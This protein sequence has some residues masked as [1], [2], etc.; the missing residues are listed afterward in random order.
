MDKDSLA[1]TKWNCIYH[2]VFIPKYRR[3]VMY[4]Q[5]HNVTSGRC[6]S[7]IQLNRCVHYTRKF[8]KSN[9]NFQ[10]RHTVALFL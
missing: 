4:G 9:N 6:L 5:R 8:P 7:F 10:T 1:H 3:K 2:I